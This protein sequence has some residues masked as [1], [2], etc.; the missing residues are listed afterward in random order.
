MR[1]TWLDAT[2]VRYSQTFFSLR[3]GLVETE[4]SFLKV[5]FVILSFLSMTQPKL[6]EGLLLIIQP[7]RESSEETW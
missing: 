6:G 7:L 3:D 4:C 1:N 5:G 2:V